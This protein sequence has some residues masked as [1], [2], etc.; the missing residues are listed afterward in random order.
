MKAQLDRV[1][2]EPVRLKIMAIL[3]RGEELDFNF[4]LG[5]LSL[6]KGNLSRHAEKLE[7]ANYVKI[8]KSFSGNIPKTGYQI[9]QKGA[10]V[11]AQYWKNVDAIRRLGQ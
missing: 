1:I 7:A 5:A 8:K 4:L 2:H 9:T 10:S 6:T 3:S 11:L